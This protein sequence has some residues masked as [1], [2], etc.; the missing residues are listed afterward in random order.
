[1][2]VFAQKAFKGHFLNEREIIIIKKKKQDKNQQIKRKK[3]E[4]VETNA[5][6]MILLL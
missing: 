4:K 5:Y 2:I 6:T 3:T 1:M